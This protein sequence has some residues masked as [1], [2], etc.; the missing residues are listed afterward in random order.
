M[1]SQRN[2]YHGIAV[3]H[4]IIDALDNHKYGELSPHWRRIIKFIYGDV[5][6]STYVYAKACDLYGKP[7]IEV[8]VKGQRH[9]ISVKSGN[10]KAVHTE[11]IHLF[12]D[13]LIKNSIDENVV[14]DYRLYHFGDSTL[15]GKGERRMG[16]QEV[17]TYFSQQIADFN[18]TFLSNK[19]LT[20]KFVERVVFKG[21]N[22]DLP[23]ADFLYHG[24]VNDG[25]ICSKEQ[26]RRFVY[27]KPFTSFINPHV[28]ML[29]LHPAARYVN[30]EEKN[31]E[32][33]YLVEV[34]WPNMR[35]DVGFIGVYMR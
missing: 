12:T 33:R 11:P 26:V 25:V 20:W 30:G 16:H 17:M 3:E 6:L 34:S 32:K 8:D 23:G 7:D 28:G 27:K 14:N 29:T 19:D 10:A 5:D 24:N 13:W 2:F 1:N 22:P 18:E 31:P 9:Y 15:D 4:S 35:N 21:N